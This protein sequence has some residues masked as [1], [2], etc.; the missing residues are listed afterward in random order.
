[1]MSKNFFGYFLQ[2]QSLMSTCR[3]LVEMSESMFKIELFGGNKGF[4]AFPTLPVPLN[5]ISTRRGT[6]DGSG[7]S[8]TSN[9][10]VGASESFDSM[11]SVSSSSSEE[12][13]Q[14]P[15]QP[16]TGLLGERSLVP[17]NGGDVVSKIGNGGDVVS[18]MRGPGG[19]TSSPRPAEK[20]ADLPHL[21][22]TLA[23]LSPPQ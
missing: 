19:E 17:V 16:S 1:M 6:E 18:A 8:A 20:A 21:P 15:S 9:S 14:S 12:S 11:T 2:S 13:T 4:R 23:P 22:G 7:S 3:A 5:S 10:S